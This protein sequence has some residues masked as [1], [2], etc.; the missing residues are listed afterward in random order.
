MN[1]SYTD[2]Y[3]AT[4]PD[5][6]KKRAVGI[7]TPATCNICIFAVDHL[8]GSIERIFCRHHKLWID[9]WNSCEYAEAGYVDM[10]HYFEHEM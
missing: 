10:V 2:A 9:T 6:A 1:T 3:A 5:F 8:I 7:S 4:R